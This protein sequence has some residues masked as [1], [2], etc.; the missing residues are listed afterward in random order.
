MKKGIYILLSVLLT[1]CLASCALADS[2]AK[3]ALT[4]ENWKS[5]DGTTIE[6]KDDGTGVFTYVTGAAPA[7][8]TWGIDGEKMQYSFDTYPSWKFNLTSGEK[9]GQPVL[10]TDQGGCFYK[11]SYVDE[12]LAQYEGVEYTVTPIALGETIS[13][14][15]VDMKIDSYRTGKQMTGSSGSGMT[16]I[17]QSD[18]EIIFALFG[19][20]ENTGGDALKLN[21]IKAEMIFDDESF[22]P[23]K[24]AEYDGSF[25]TSLDPLCDGNLVF[26]ASVPKTLAE[27]YGTLT[28][29]IA[30]NDG[31]QEYPA[32]YQMAQYV[33]E[34]KVTRD[35]LA[36]AE[37]VVERKRTCFE[38]V[39]E[40]PDP[41]SFVDVFQSGSSKSSVNGKVSKNVVK[42][43]PSAGDDITELL[44]IYLEKI[45]EEGFTVQSSGGTYTIL[46][47]GKKLVSVSIS[48]GVMEFNLIP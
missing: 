5:L 37:N 4:A 22:T 8:F 18:D 28:L 17:A 12:L 21:C 26:G 9:D 41:T 43:K 10:T 19:T 33:Y 39:P 30:F 44:N 40:L 45:Q 14:D 24:Y 13:V 3:E 42:F 46:S 7:S 35:E 15:G 20:I 25:Q 38:D 48:S 11:A 29:R 32:L 1:I 23:W 16:L 31:L 34:L 6:I 47:G 36:G 2:L 27:N